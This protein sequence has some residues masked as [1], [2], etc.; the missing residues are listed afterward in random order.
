MSVDNYKFQ[1]ACLILKQ[2][3]VF[4]SDQGLEDCLEYSSWEQ[5]S[6]NLSV[7]PK[8]F[9]KIKIEAKEIYNEPNRQ[10]A[11]FNSFWKII[12]P[13]LTAIST[14]SE[15][16]VIKKRLQ[17]FI[18][19]K[20]LSIKNKLTGF[21]DSPQLS[22]TELQQELKWI[23][24]LVS[25]GDKDCLIKLWQKLQFCDDKR[26]TEVLNYEIGKLNDLLADEIQNFNNS[27]TQYYDGIDLGGLSKNSTTDQLSVI[28]QLLN[29]G[30]QASLALVG[31]LV[32]HRDKAIRDI[33]I[34]GLLEFE[35]VD[36]ITL[37]ELMEAHSDKQ[38]RIAA[39]KIRQQVIGKETL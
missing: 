3:L 4:L 32:L 25:S 38:Y 7:N 35:R 14:N 17:N 13:N 16:V 34:E 15:I 23:N 30:D 5:L 20:K 10:P 29:Y 21:S 1:V 37:I 19:L 36:L 39:L 18:E 6:P 26:L 22:Q 12:V 24:D 11:D 9:D 2:T 31:L 8:I 33:I 27:N 28:S